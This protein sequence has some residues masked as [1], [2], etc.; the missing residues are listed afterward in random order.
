MGTMAAMIMAAYLLY[1]YLNE[2]AY[3]EVLA[4]Y[5]ASDPVLDPDHA[6][7]EMEFEDLV[8]QIE[9]LQTSEERLQAALDSA[10]QENEDLRM[11]IE[12]LQTAGNSD[13]EDT[14]DR[15]PAILSADTMEPEELNHD[16]GFSE[17]VKSLLNLDEE[18]LAPIVSQMSDNQL[19]RLYMGGGSLQQEKLLRALEPDR[20]AS[21]I[22]EVML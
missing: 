9:N 4:M 16:E 22:S 5:T 7:P 3:Q 10:E 11:D 8:S 21:L 14:A 12:E 2:E 1:P 6:Y 17:R 20:A 19:I 15:N 13:G 18:E